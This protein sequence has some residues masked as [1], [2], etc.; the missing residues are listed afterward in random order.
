[1]L[2]PLFAASSQKCPTTRRVEAFSP[3]LGGGAPGCSQ[4]RQRCPS[5]TSQGA[6]KLSFNANVEP[7]KQVTGEEVSLLLISHI[8]PKIKK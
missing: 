6:F 2:R 4:L 7:E 3:N 8:A 5:V 1:M